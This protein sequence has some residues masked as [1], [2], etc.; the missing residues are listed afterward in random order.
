MIPLFDFSTFNFFFT[1][2]SILFTFLVIPDDVRMWRKLFDNFV[3]VL[4]NKTENQNMRHIQKVTLFDY[5]KIIV[6]L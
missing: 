6:Q 4:L 5:K 1:K 3:I 2:F